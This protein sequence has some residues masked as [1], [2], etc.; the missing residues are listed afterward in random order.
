MQFP[1][2][3]VD[4]Q[5]CIG[6][7]DDNGDWEPYGYCVVYD[8]EVI[9][10]G[11]KRTKPEWCPLIECSRAKDCISKADVL[12]TFSELYDIFDDYH[13]IRKMFN[14]IYDRLNN[15]ATVEPVRDCS[16]CRFVFYKREE[17]DEH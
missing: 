12:E 16:D 15:L 3:C 7:W 14:K 17:E 8:K 5:L 4:C 1:Q 2:S 13:E 10:E 11:K 6:D 9:E